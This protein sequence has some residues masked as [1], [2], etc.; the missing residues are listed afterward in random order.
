MPPKDYE[1]ALVM[2]VYNEEGCIAA[3]VR[4]W[5]DMLHT[6]G[7]RFVMIVIDDGSRDR[8]AE[9]LREFAGDER[10]RVIHQPN[11]GHGPTILRGYAEAV[12]LADWVFQCDSDNQMGPES[13]GGLWQI[14]HG[15]DA[16]FGCRQHRRQNLQRRLISFCS[17]IAVG[18][19][20]A[21]GV[22]DVNTPYRLMRSSIL[23]P[24]LESIPPGT[25]AP[26][27]ILC[28]ALAVAGANVRS[29]PVS[30]RPRQTGHASIVRWRLWS[31]AF[32]SFSQTLRCSRQIRRSQ[33]RVRHAAKV[34]DATAR[35]Q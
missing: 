32:I 30:C 2:P 27:V 35:V 10:I 29:V 14:R 15:T 7:I 19:L 25:F 31:V 22:E 34:L 13:F 16:V 23:Q 9:I 3:V 12:T 1:L 24:I 11:A 28:G 17:R 26:N 21:R 5:R 6:S 18:L 20:F 4:A 33:R 8:T